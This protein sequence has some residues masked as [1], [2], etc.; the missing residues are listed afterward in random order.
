MPPNG[1][2]GGN[3]G[4]HDAHN[5]AWKLAASLDGIG[6]PKLLATYDAERRPV[7]AFTAEQAYSRYV[8]RTAPELGTD[9]IQPVAHDFEIELGYVYR[10]DSI[11]TENDATPRHGDPRDLA[12]TPGSR[13]PHV[14]L[15]DGSASRSTIDLIGHQFCLLAGSRGAAWAEAANVVDLRSWRGARPARRVHR[16]ALHWSG[17][18]PGTDAGHRSG[19]G[20]GLL[21]T[22]SGPAR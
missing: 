16:V 22:A 12:G 14:E 15:V 19:H 18:R 5:L 21:A 8:T 3:T 10:S 11:A 4:I 13:A 9:D 1:G 2:F 7:C 20:P 6:G 17:R